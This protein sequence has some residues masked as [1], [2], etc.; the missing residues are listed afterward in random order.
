MHPSS[1]AGRDGV[2]GRRINLHPGGCLGVRQQVK[3]RDWRSGWGLGGGRKFWRD[4]ST[5]AGC[6]LTAR[7]PLQ[8]PWARGG[9]CLSPWDWVLPQFWCYGA[10]QGAGVCAGEHTLLQGPA[11]GA[12]V[13]PSSPLGPLGGCWWLVSRLG[14]RTPSPPAVPPGS[15]R[16][17]FHCSEESELI[18]QYSLG[19]HRSFLKFLVLVFLKLRILR[20]ETQHHLA[21]E[22][23]LQY[24]GFGYP[25]HLAAR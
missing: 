21:P 7:S 13:P 11:T 5:R 8:Q 1:S 18:Q 19:Q 3:A 23:F 6:E 17:F 22:A 4:T 15:A 9:I 14:P 10:A 25:Q 2:S 20:H 24:C 16:D 12:R